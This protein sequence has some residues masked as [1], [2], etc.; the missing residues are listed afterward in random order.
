[1]YIGWTGLAYSRTA[2][3][4]QKAHQ[5]LNSLWHETRVEDI[6]FTFCLM[7]S[8]LV[9]CH[10]LFS[11]WWAFG[12]NRLYDC[13]LNQSNQYTFIF[14]IVYFSSL[15]NFL[16]FKDICKWD[17]LPFKLGNKRYLGCRKWWSLEVSGVMR[18]H[19]HLL[20]CLGDLSLPSHPAGLGTLVCLRYPSD[21]GS[22]SLP[23]NLLRWTK[24][25]IK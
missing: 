2:C 12:R 4:A 9:S 7:S 10:I 16:M 8:T 23:G 5:R 21:Q 22:P 25:I 13:K 11:R 20:G 3:F 19:L 17:L 1:M 6:L 18:S 14:I 15:H 24:I